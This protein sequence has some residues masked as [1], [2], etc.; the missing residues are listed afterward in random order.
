MKNVPVGQ[1]EVSKTVEA[2]A[3]E[4][5]NYGCQN[6]YILGDVVE[7]LTYVV[8]SQEGNNFPLNIK[9]NENVGNVFYKDVRKVTLT[10]KDKEIVYIVFIRNIVVSVHF[11]KA[12]LSFITN[13][14]GVAHKMACVD[15]RQNVHFID[16]YIYVEKSKA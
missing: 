6:F 7:S 15:T 9:R 10:K 11:G 5:F 12:G 8:D 3:I 1:D 4:S 13:K 16:S 2:D 14:K